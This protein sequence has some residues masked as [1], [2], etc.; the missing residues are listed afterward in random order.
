MLCPDKLRG[1]ARA[2]PTFREAILMH[3]IA[4][5]ALHPLIPHI[6]ASSLAEMDTLITSINR[7]PQ[8]RTTLYGTPP[9]DQRR[10]SY[11]AAPL[12]PVVQ[13]PL[14]RAGRDATRAS[15]VNA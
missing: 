9:S 2:G 7:V 14:R 13:T 6:Q 15:W 5:L 8:Q 4:R 10:A 3:A 12:A 11:R 1:R